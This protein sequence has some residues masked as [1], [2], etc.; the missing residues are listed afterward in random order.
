ML[1]K[2]D[3]YAGWWAGSPDDLGRPEVSP[4]LGDLSGLPPALMFCGTRDTWRRAAGCSPPR[5]RGRLGPH[6][7][8]GSPT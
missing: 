7:R 1:S 6:L 2:L 8:R 5:G 3:A 4:A